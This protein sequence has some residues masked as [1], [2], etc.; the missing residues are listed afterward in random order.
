MEVFLMVLKII[1]IVLLCILGLILLVVLLVLFCPFSYRLDAAKTEQVTAKAKVSWLLH[2]V[3]V[4]VLWQAGLNLRLKLFGIPFYDKKKKD[5]KKA[6][7]AE[8]DKKAGKSDHKESE[9]V[10]S[11]EKESEEDTAEAEKEPA[12]SSA[13]SE[14]SEKEELKEADSEKEEEKSSESDETDKAE[15]PEKKKKPKSI[16]GFF[17]WIDRM[18]DRFWDFLDRAPE[19]LAEWL[20]FLPDKAEE[21]IDTVE[22]YDRLLNSE[23]TA[24][25]IEAVKKHGGAILFHVLPYRTDGTLDYYDDDPANVAKIYEYQ[26]FALPILDRICGKKGNFDILALQDEKKVE[27]T[28]RIKGRIFLIVLAWHGLCLIL[29]KKVRIFLKKLKRQEA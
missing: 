11:E 7:K 16:D 17:D 18:R 9:D 14:T 5:A 6:A 12:E 19:K 24:Q 20:D 15:A 2:I 8:K 25:V 21:L 3:V 10:S 4:E 1:G 22:Y 28:L 26:V 13:D 23:G 29:N 27:F